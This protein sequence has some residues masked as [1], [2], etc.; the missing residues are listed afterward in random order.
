MSGRSAGHGAPQHW[1]TGCPWAAAPSSRPRPGSDDAS[2]PLSDAD[3]PSLRITPPQA[4]SEVEPCGEDP[5]QEHV[6]GS[7][8]A[9]VFMPTT[10]KP[11]SARRQ[12]AFRMIDRMSVQDSAHVDDVTSSATTADVKVE[13]IAVVQEP[14]GSPDDQG[15]D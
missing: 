15:D 2:T 12:R 14:I 7:G 10:P 11:G 8:R 5:K 13:V 3:R 4:D 9:C 1:A 6:E